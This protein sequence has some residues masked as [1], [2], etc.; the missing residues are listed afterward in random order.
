MY[1][2]VKRDGTREEFNR[3][4][5]ITAI[6]KAFAAVDN[7]NIDSYCNEKSSKIADYIED[8]CKDKELNVEEIQNLVQIGLM[9]TRRKDVAEAFII[10][11]NNRTMIRE[12]NSKLM[13]D[14]DNKI[15]GKIN[16]RQNANVDG[17]SFGGRMGEAADVIM[18]HKAL[19]Y[20]YMSSMATWNHLKNKIYTHDLSHYVL[21]DHNCLSIPFDDVL[22]K[23]F[24]TRQ[25]DVR[26][27]KSINTALQLVAVVKQ[28]QSLNQFGGVSA[29][30]LDH[31]LVPY[32]RLSFF[33]HY[34]IEYLKTLD[35][36]YELDILEMD[37][38]DLDDWI[39]ENRNKYLEEM[40]LSLEDFRFDNIEK[41][42]TALYQR[43]LF[44]TRKE[45]Y[46]AVEAMY[47]NLNTLQS[48]SGN[49]LNMGGC[50]YRNVA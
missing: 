33:K 50:C 30:H 15:L 4:K 47:H 9:N 44:E 42:D 31:S 20:G 12:K 45:T 41:L 11:R 23:G 5:I 22:A 32:V 49:Q 48:R 43:A 2:I 14:V 39:E 3:V 16:D 40:N 8:I 28:L 35:E 21:G 6:E 27:A 34:L 25:T 17:L 46:Q 37:E 26:P 36:F 29:T 7:G 13:L 1:C 38:D 24:N 19:H 18:K 10:Y